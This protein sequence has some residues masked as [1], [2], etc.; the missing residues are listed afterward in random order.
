M[1]NAIIY[2]RKAAEEQV[3]DCKLEEQKTYC[4]KYAQDK[5]YEVTDV[6]SV[7]EAGSNNLRDGITNL[8]LKCKKGDIKKVIAYDASRISRVFIDYL[9]IENQLKEM[10]VELE[11]VTAL[12]SADVDYMRNASI[13][14]HKYYRRMMSERIKRGIR[15][16]K[17]R[18]EINSIK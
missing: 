16:A 15:F 1:N 5:G 6:I 4:I 8:F 17:L 7:V 9:A 2:C 3:G 18:R 12:D 10:G 13:E 11:L 14:F